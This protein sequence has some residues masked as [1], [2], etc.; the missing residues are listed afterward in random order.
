MR[1]HQH[2]PQGS[3][4]SLSITHRYFAE[5]DHHPLERTSQY[6]PVGPCQQNLEPWTL[7]SKVFFITACFSV[8]TRAGPVRALTG[9]CNKAV[10]N[11]PAFA[12]AFQCP[13]GSPM[14]P[15]LKCLYFD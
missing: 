6:R 10:S 1:H 11:F 7:S 3:K 15:A 8:C 5:G 4:N 2:C 14:N 13:T 12:R 9:D